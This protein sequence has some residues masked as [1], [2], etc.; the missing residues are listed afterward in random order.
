M[1]IQTAALIGSY[2]PRQCGIATFTKDLRDSMA[3]EG[4]VRTLVL[5]M[6]DIPSGY[7]YPEEVR[8]QIQANRLKDYS[9]AADMLNI[10]QVD[11]VVLEH[12]FGIF[13]G[14]AGEHILALLRRLRMPII[15]TLHTVLAQPNKE[16]IAVMK[17]LITYS[18]CLVVLCSRALQMLKSIYNVPAEKIAIIPHG[19]PDVPF[20][21]PSF[22]KDKF[23][24]EG[25]SV[26]LTF[27]LLSP[28]KG[29]ELALSA[30]PKIVSK[31]PEVTYLVLGA[32][33]P[34]ILRMDGNAYITL[35]ER[36]AEK[37]GVREHV[38]FHNRFDFPADVIHFKHRENRQSRQY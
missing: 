9:V 7:D 22:Y 21:D 3:K 14:R 6:D 29:I 28:N 13:G 33:H 36:M 30:L 38:L 11:V 19:I 10:N 23:E 17:E 26:L 12:E 18:D 2:V 4:D 27:G 34:H 15:T 37:L 35:L 24:L 1:K 31:Y 5:A 8:F 25:R 20:V 16:Q 32:I